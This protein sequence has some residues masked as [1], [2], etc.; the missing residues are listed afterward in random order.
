MNVALLDRFRGFF[1]FGAGV[2][3]GGTAGSAEGSLWRAPFRR[4]AEKA[5]MPR[6]M[7]D[8][9]GTG[10]VAPAIDLPE[11]VD[12]ENLPALLERAYFDSAHGSAAI[13]DSLDRLLHSAG[14][15]GVPSHEAQV[16]SALERRLSQQDHPD[17]NRLQWC[18]SRMQGLVARHDGTAD[19][20][21]L[22]LR[23]TIA[24]LQRTLGSSTTDS[25]TSAG[26]PAGWLL[27]NDLLAR[28]MR[29]S[30]SA[31]EVAAAGAAYL[32]Q[33]AH[34][35][36]ARCLKRAVDRGF[37]DGG[38]TEFLLGQCSFELDEFA[39]ASSWFDSA[40]ERGWPRGEVS[41]WQ[42]VALYETGRL[43]ECEELARTGLVHATGNDA[44]ELQVILAAIRL[45]ALDV[46]GA[47]EL[48]RQALAA[49]PLNADAAYGLGLCALTRGDI[50]GAR[51][52]FHELSRC[53]NGAALQTLGLGLLSADIGNFAEAIP[54]L[55]SAAAF[56]PT[57][58]ALRARLGDCL[59]AAGEYP[60][61][62][63]YLAE[64]A[65]LGADE[66]GI[67]VRYG[68]ALLFGGDLEGSEPLLRAYA[69]CGA[70]ELDVE[71]YLNR[72]ADEARTRAIERGDYVEAARGALSRPVAAG[73]DSERLALLLYSAARQQLERG[74]ATESTEQWLT[75]AWELLRCPETF[76]GAL[77]A[78]VYSAATSSLD[79]L[80]AA[81]GEQV[82]ASSF[83]ALVRL[84]AAYHDGRIADVE[85][86]RGRAS[87]EPLVQKAAD[88][89]V[90]H[91]RLGQRTGKPEASE[92]ERFLTI[93]GS[94]EMMDL[95]AGEKATLNMV[96]ATVL[97]TAYGRVDDMV[98]AVE[99]L[100]A[101]RSD[102]FWS[103]ALILLWFVKA[104]RSNYAADFEKVVAW[105]AA[106]QTPTALTADLGRR[107][108]CALVAKMLSEDA[109]DFG[110]V[111]RQLEAIGESANDPETGVLLDTLQAL[112]AK[113]SLESAWIAARRGDYGRA[114]QTWEQL[115]SRGDNRA[116]HP[117]A[118]LLF[119]LG[120]DQVSANDDHDVQTLG[121]A[122]PFWH[123]IFKDDAFWE[124]MKRRGDALHS[125]QYPYRPEQIDA[126]RSALPGDSLEVLAQLAVRRT[127]SSQK[128]KARACVE[129]IEASPFGAEVG[130]QVLEER[131]ARFL[132]PDSLLASQGSGRFEQALAAAET[133]LDCDQKSRTGMRIALQAA[134]YQGEAIGMK[135]I[136]A[137]Q[138]LPLFARVRRRLSTFPNDV[139]VAETHLRGPCKR[140]WS[141]FA[142][143]L[144]KAL[145]DNLSEYSKASG[146][147]G[148]EPRRSLLRNARTCV[149]TALRHVIPACGQWQTEMADVE[150]FKRIDGQL[151][152]AGHGPGSA[153]EY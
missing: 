125:N 70:V 89:F 96:V 116:A 38:R 80:L 97:S 63:Q 75:R 52:S 140:Y 129:A 22:R 28:S 111:L 40:V 115:L 24:R 82:P 37:E 127:K 84:L 76:A 120:Y 46:T 21:W 9:V 106:C 59:F 118:V 91:L 117:L 103:E 149:D 143:A 135:E 47:L 134:F 3:S 136:K 50:A 121:A 81:A 102:G 139:L 110:I 101:S 144:E 32:E 69:E 39:A 86:E 5:R 95:F 6:S 62:A 55:T 94:P 130:R 53:Q 123:R 87:R 34:A 15:R 74:M 138:S 73:A 152:Q 126:L 131:Y 119:R 36:A 100:S 1:G 2:D 112:V 64:A 147:P 137:A 44:A 114:R 108:Q 26:R 145:L 61:A 14:V 60:A 33:G 133:V 57:H 23:G 67:L 71:P 109:P 43:R 68:L 78:Q 4:P 148:N 92:I 142:A 51:H 122:L 12:A 150:F 77:V 107:A 54:Y 20:V 41:R 128:E 42:A 30:S 141:E 104:V 11:V 66:P 146:D 79:S 8:Y 13:I 151:I 25:A 132:A 65:K 49:A 27:A 83:V 90:L 7:W 113:D 153:S 16:L 31:A 45:A 56:F 48:Y 19:K 17:R 93:V 98:K 124:N 105:C 10:F 88:F 58:V 29:R 85:K 35:L 18:L 99:K 72:I